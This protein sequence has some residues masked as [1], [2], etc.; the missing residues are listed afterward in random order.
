MDRVGRVGQP[1]RVVVDVDRGGT[2]RDPF[3]HR[4]VEFGPGCRV[5]SGPCLVQDEQL[6]LGQQRLGDGHLLAGA[7][8]ELGEGRARVLGRAEA[9]QPLMGARGRRTAV[10]TVDAPD[11]AQIAHGG[12]RQYAREPFGDVRRA[13]PAV[14]P[15]LAG[16]VDPGDQPEQ[17]GLSGAVGPGD[18]DQ[19]ACRE[20]EIHSAQYPGAAQSVAAADRLEYQLDAAF[21]GTSS[22]GRTMTKPSPWSISWTASPEPPRIMEPKDCERLR[23]VVRLALHPTTASVST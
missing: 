23:E 22:L 10:E 16:R 2:R 17:G 7:L 18:P 15:A 3:G 21:C 5:E 6:G 12:E 19:G 13:G 4:A 20:F 9:L 14:D 8:G 11:V 1:Q